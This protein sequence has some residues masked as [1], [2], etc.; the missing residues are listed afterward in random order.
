VLTRSP[1]IAVIVDLDLNT[2]AIW[3]LTR[4]GCLTPAVGAQH[5]ADAKALAPS[6]GAKQFIDCSILEGEVLQP[7]VAQSVGIS[8]EATQWDE[9]ERSAASSAQVLL[10]RDFSEVR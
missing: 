10:R 5:W 3:I 2:V 1:A 6:I 9:R 4:E 7:M 8:S